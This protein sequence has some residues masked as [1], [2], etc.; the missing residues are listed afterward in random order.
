MH[1]LHREFE[2]MSG[3]AHEEFLVSLGI[4]AEEVKRIREESRK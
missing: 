2:K 4:E 3:D 1:R